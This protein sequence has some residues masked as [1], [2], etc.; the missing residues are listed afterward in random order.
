M[1]VGSSYFHSLNVRLQKRLSRSLSITGNYIYSKLIDQST[2][3]NDTD[4]RPEK[5]IGVFDHTHR[6]VIAV[7]YD[8]PF[9]KGK[10]FDMHSRW[11]NTAFGGWHVNGMYT[12]QT[13]QPFT[14]MHTS[15]TTIGDYTYFGAPLDYHPR[16]TNG[17][18]FNINAFTPPVCLGT[19]G[20]AYA[21]CLAANQLSYHVRSFS[22]TFSSLRGDGVNQLNGSVLKRIDLREKMYLQL[23]FECF[24]IMNHPIFAFPNV[25]E[26]NSAFGLITSQST[27]RAASAAPSSCSKRSPTRRHRLQFPTGRLD[28]HERNA[29]RFLKL[30]AQPLQPF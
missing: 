17:L 13:G 28:I 20:A 9:G 5:R 25:A 30:L 6:G 8:L 15:S 10:H 11:L 14:F 1:T 7:T 12:R 29:R 24:N 18:A 19:A 2:W 27:S 26:T 4:P 22:T 3:L 23:R 16:E 21:S